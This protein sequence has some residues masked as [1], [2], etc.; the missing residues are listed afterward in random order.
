MDPIPSS[1]LVS[2]TSSSLSL[3]KHAPASAV[4]KDRAQGRENRGVGSRNTEGQ[5]SSFEGGQWPPC[6][7]IYGMGGPLQFHL[8]PPTWGLGLG[9]C[10]LF[11]ACFC[12]P[13]FSPLP[14]FMLLLFPAWLEVIA[15][16]GQFYKLTHESLPTITVCAPSLVSF[17]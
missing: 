8:L 2:S 11:S 16:N 13:P 17:S 10:L 3:F 9:W 6:C 14:I 15:N 4:S 12:P 7:Y 5:C 1:C